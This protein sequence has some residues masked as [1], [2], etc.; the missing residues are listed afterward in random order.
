MLDAQSRGGLEVEVDAGQAVGLF[1]HADQHPGQAELAQ[2]ADALVVQLDVHQHEAVD[3]RAAGDAP[4]A[5]G[6]LVAGQ[7]QHVVRRVRG[8]W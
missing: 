3:E 5:L 6:A 1:G 2:D 8:R 7:Q 4:H